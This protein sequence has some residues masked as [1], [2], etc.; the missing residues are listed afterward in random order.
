LA[1]DQGLESTIEA[2]DDAWMDLLRYH[3]ARKQSP[4]HLVTRA[5]Q[6]LRGLVG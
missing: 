1:A 2:L 5:F 4:D 6:V 3:S